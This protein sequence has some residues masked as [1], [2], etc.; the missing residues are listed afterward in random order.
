MTSRNVRLSSSSSCTQREFTDGSV[1]SQQHYNTTPLHNN[2]HRQSGNPV[3]TMATATTPTMLFD[4]VNVHGRIT[5]DNVYQNGLHALKRL[6]IR[7]LTDQRI[8]VKMRSNLRHQIAF[9]LNNENINSVPDNRLQGIAT[10]TV[11]W[12]HMSADAFYFNQVFNYVNHID[13]LELEPYQTL[14]LILAFLPESRHLNRSGSSSGGGGGGSNGN[15]NGGGGGSGG[16]GDEDT[17]TNEAVSPTGFT[18]PDPADDDNMYETF[19]VT[20]SLFFFGY[21]LETDHDSAAASAS[22]TLIE[23]HQQDA[24]VTTTLAD[25]QLSIKFRASVCR[26]VMWTDVV[27][28][29]LNFEDCMLGQEYHKDFT[30]QNNSDIDLYWLL[31]TVDLSN[32]DREEWLRFSDAETGKPLSNGDD[33]P[34]IPGHS[35]RRIRLTF[36]PKEVGEFSYDLQIENANDARNVVQTKVHAVVRSVLREESL[37]ISSG[38]SLDFADCV[39]GQWTSR[40]IVLNNV[41][42]SSVEVRFIPESADMVFD[43]KAALDQDNN[44]SKPSRPVCMDD[45]YIRSNMFTNDII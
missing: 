38:N 25:Y 45:I 12:S 39:S 42:E 29:G 36:M 33:Q 11:D 9:Q 8:L 6:E 2:Q 24:M 34:A 5:L 27:E 28:T 17:E 7:N 37:V 20:G 1:A 4:L 41:G 22:A 35:H 14:P 18:I 26:S 3:T 13:Q 23:H 31:N 32:L 44:S 43:I 16:G 40:Q 10:N 21:Y 15:A 30:I 19:N